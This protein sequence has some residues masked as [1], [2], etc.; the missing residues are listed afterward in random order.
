MH[1]REVPATSPCRKSLEI[2]RTSYLM[3]YKFPSLLPS[4]QI[5]FPYRNL[6]SNTKDHQP[7]DSCLPRLVADNCPCNCRNCNENKFLS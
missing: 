1:K 3:N 4:F 2:Q 6:L 7:E 5:N